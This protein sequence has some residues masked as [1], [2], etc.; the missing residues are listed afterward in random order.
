VLSQFP[1]TRND[2]DATR[3]A[4]ASLQ[5]HFG[6]DRVREIEPTTASEDFGLFAAARNVPAVFW[7][8]GGCREG[9]QAG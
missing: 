8:I 5:R 6:S 2:E 1:L 7:V 9:R 4:A 3:N